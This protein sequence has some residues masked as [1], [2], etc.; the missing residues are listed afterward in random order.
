MITT[1]KQVNINANNLI[2]S[3]SNAGYDIDKGS[4]PYYGL[5]LYIYKNGSCLYKMSGLS[6]PDHLY[7][8]YDLYELEIALNDH[9]IE[10]VGI[11]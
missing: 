8:E 10:W 11:C 5:C 6:D 7:D 3:L 4:D 9:N 2:K 1:T